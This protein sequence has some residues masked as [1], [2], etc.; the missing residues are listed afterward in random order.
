MS[1]RARGYSLNPPG[2]SGFQSSPRVVPPEAHLMIAMGA[3]VA[4][5][6][7]RAKLTSGP[8]TFPRGL[9]V[10]QPLEEFIS[11]RPIEYEYITFSW[12]WSSPAK[13]GK[14]LM[15]VAREWEP[16]MFDCPAKMK[17]R[18]VL[19]SDWVALA[20][21]TSARDRQIVWRNRRIGGMAVGVDERGVQPF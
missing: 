7:V 1:W 9:R 20:T 5:A 3:L 19:V 21:V 11:S 12:G 13:G 10:V 18:R 16:T 8:I 6:T 15:S 17:T 14:S 4:R 2:E